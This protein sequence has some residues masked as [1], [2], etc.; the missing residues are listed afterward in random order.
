MEAFCGRIYRKEVKHK[1]FAILHLLQ[2]AYLDREESKEREQSHTEL[3]KRE[4]ST[5]ENRQKKK[6]V[7]EE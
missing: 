3:R 6:R 4:Q 7:L 2:Q 5:E 1:A